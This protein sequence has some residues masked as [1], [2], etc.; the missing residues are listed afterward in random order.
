MDSQQAALG[1][2]S[3][4]EK[5]LHLC[6]NCSSYAVAPKW[7]ELLKDR[8]VRNVWCCDACRYEFETFAV[9]SDAKPLRP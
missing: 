6:P 1:V 5:P 2:N 4:N 9:F 3:A 7:S 8:C